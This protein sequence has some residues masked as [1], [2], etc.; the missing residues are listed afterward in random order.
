MPETI[1]NNYNTVFIIV[2]WL[3][4]QHIYLPIKKIAT[5]AITANL[6][7]RYIWRFKD[8]L[9]I[10]ISNYKPQFINIFLNKLSYFCQIKLKLSIS[11]HS[12]T[13]SQIE[14]IN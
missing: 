3:S 1:N 14:I 4:K 10:I 8:C 12:Q 13:D 11:V 9:K 7:Y 2:D 5:A 6:F